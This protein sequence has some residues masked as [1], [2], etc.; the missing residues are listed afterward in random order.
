MAKTKTIICNYSNCGTYY[1]ALVLFPGYLNELVRCIRY[2][3]NSR[4]AKVSEDTLVQCL[5]VI[6]A[7]L[8]GCASGGG[9]KGQACR[10]DAMLTS[11]ALLRQIH[12][13]AIPV[14]VM[15]N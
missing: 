7:T 11:L 10:L 9:R 14:Q 3:L 4:F 13:E 1:I 2:A 12:D 6:T 5:K 8:S 15:Y